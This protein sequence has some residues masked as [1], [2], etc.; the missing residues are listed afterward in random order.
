[1]KTTE[2]VGF[3]REN[4]GTTE[5]KELRAQG[6]AP[7]VV[8]GGEDGPVHFHAPMYL[9]KDLLYTPDAYIVKLNVEGVE[10]ECILQG[11]QFHPVSDTLIHV[12]FLEIFDD[13]P[14]KIEVPV[15][16]KGNAPG[17]IAGGQ[18]FLKQ[19]KVTVKALPKELPEYVN[20]DISSLELAQSIRVREVQTEGNFEIVNPPNVTI[21]TI[22]V[23]RALKTQQAQDQEA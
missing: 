6:N 16:L 1:M 8:Y 9:F 20:V 19:K 3:K 17:A 11:V 21:V 7:C 23:P 2:I 15:K 13:K 5:A 18:I 22:L 14:V 12:D 10:K 4:L